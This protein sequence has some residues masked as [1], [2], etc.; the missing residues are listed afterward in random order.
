MYILT[1][2]KPLPLTELAELQK[3]RFTVVNFYQTIT[4][5]MSKYIPLF[6]S[7]SDPPP[8]SPLGTALKLFDSILKSK[9]RCEDMTPPLLTP[10]D[11][12]VT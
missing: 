10:F 4:T 7:L 8:P 12:N 11:H 9:L 2:V 5:I 6:P 3:N 1:L